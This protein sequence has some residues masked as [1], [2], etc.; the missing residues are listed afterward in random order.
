MSAGAIDSWVDLNSYIAANCTN[1]ESNLCKSI[2]AGFKE[3]GDQI[4]GALVSTK[5]N[6]PLTGGD[7]LGINLLLDTLDSSSTS[8][9]STLAGLV[10]KGIL[11][12]S[13][14][15]VKW[16]PSLLYR[17]Q[18]DPTEASSKISW[19]FLNLCR[20]CNLQRSRMRASIS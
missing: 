5:R 3:R 16:P 7:R 15:L 13:L 20:Y 19:S 6:E 9:S 8:I 2:E 17:T 12:S 1:A 11:A 18:P 14:S 4:I 10:K